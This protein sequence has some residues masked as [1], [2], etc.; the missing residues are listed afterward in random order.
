MPR[1]TF[2]QGY[3]AGR[4]DYEMSAKRNPGF[5]TGLEPGGELS[6]GYTIILSDIQAYANRIF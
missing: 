1:Q 5:I 2:Q 4:Y 3:I 6:G